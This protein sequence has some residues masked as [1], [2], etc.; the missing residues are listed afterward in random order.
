VIYALLAGLITLIGRFFPAFGSVD[1]RVAL[2]SMAATR[3][4]GALTLLA[5]TVV[6]LPSV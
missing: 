1:L 5:L 6:R 4:R 3:A 2:R